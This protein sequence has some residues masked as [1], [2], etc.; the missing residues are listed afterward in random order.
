MQETL[1][2]RVGKI[3][4]NREW[5]PTPVFL[6]G[7]FQGQRS[8][9]GYSPWGCKESDTTGQLG[10]KITSTNVIIKINTILA[11]TNESTKSNPILMF[12]NITSD[13]NNT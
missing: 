1:E 12:N 3:P 13:V 11:I 4:R 5:Q 10:T 2:T 6:L 7:K 8:L 9:V